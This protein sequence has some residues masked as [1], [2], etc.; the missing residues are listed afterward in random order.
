MIE[1]LY[2]HIPFCLKICPYCSFYKETANGGKVKGFLLALLKEAERRKE[3]LRPKTIFFGGGT[4]SALSVGQLEFLLSGLREVVDCSV[5]EEWT[6][7]MNPATVSLEKAKKL[8]E[9]GVN[10]ASLGVQSWNGLELKVL[11]RVHTVH[12]AERSLEILREAEFENINMDLI[13]SIPGQTRRSWEE[14]LQRS[15]A[16]GPSHISAYCL[17]YE[18]DTEFFRRV[19]KGE[20]VPD[21]ELDA[22]L[23]VATREGLR[24]AGYGRYEVSNFALSGKECLH[25]LAY[26]QGRDY[27]GLGPGA[28]STVGEQRW[29][30]VENTTAYI[31]KMEE[32]KSVADFEE[33]ITLRIRKNERVAFGLRMASGVKSEWIGEARAKQFVKEGLLEEAGERYR[34][35]ER[36]FLVA[37]AVAAELIDGE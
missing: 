13:Y 16:L 5:V 21:E 25:N 9:Y 14:S 22:E 10:R 15:V 12:H 28:F 3:R 2:I 35:T 4:P 19:G 31:A 33:T 30:N 1:H 34:L 17:T 29:R 32:G 27:M 23:F 18:E 7:E 20:W 36:G 11:G 37:D 24:E 6:F 26:W 8:R